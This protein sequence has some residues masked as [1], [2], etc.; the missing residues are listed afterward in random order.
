MAVEFSRRDGFKAW[1]QAEA[2]LKLQP[3]TPRSLA[4][5]KRSME[6]SVSPLDRKGI[7]KRPA[8]ST[9]DFSNIPM[10]WDRWYLEG[11]QEGMARFGLDGQKARTRELGPKAHAAALHT[12]IRREQRKKA[13]KNRSR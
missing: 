13:K 1:K 12:K 10:D 5:P 4:V 11:Q 9:R 7:T 3:Q 6:S 8:E 2:G